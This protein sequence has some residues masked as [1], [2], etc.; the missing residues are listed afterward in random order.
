MSDD[1]PAAMPARPFSSAA[2]ALAGHRREQLLSMY[3]PGEEV[4]DSG[5]EL[6]EIVDLARRVTGAD[7]GQLNMLGADRQVTWHEA[8]TPSPH[9]SVPLSNSVCS[10][11]LDDRGADQVIVVPDTAADPLLR[12]HPAVTGPPGISFYAGA[13]LTS[14]HGWPMG[15]LC[16]WSSSPADL[17][18]LQRRV[19][20]QLGHAAMHILETRRRTGTANAMPGTDRRDV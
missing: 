5:S 6:A 10:A 9:R 12:D 20:R 4:D 13:P 17:D 3:R 18:E 11:V 2:D 14:T 7:A 15:M 19:L 8:G 1:A 16:V